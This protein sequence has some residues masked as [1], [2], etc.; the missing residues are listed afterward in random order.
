[1]SLL[2]GLS[3][4]ERN[5][6]QQ[7][8]AS[9]Q[10]QQTLALCALA[11]QHHELASRCVWHISVQQLLEP[12]S[13]TCCRWRS[14]ARPDERRPARRLHHAQTTI[15]CTQQAAESYGA[16][17]RWWRSGVRP[18]E[19]R[20][21]RRLQ[22]IRTASAPQARASATSSRRWAAWVREQ[23]AQLHEPKQL[24]TLSIAVSG[25]VCV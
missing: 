7:C 2:P 9:Q 15:R 16:P 23:G 17:C 5:F 11:L 4:M 14:G 3:D 25:R 6:S 21:A 19:R 18:G 24:L 8:E 13:L 12:H 22:V 1:M 10:T 20:P